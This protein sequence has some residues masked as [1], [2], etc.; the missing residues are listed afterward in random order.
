M[1]KVTSFSQCVEKKSNN[2]G[3][4]IIAVLSTYSP[5]FYVNN[6]NPNNYAAVVTEA[7][8][9][10]DVTSTTYKNQKVKKLD[11]QA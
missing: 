11:F 10:N 6:D 3:N 8:D 5:S 1:L 4:F 9:S 7:I 2:W